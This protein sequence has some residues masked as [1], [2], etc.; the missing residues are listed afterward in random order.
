MDIQAALEK[1][2]GPLRIVGLSFRADYSADNVVS[3]YA[4]E[5]S[6]RKAVRIINPTDK[7]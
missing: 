6:T 4:I 1:C 2:R 7:C 5:W 3:M